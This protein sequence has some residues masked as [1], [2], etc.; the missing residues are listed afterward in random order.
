VEAERLTY[1]GERI[2]TT[3]RSA[4]KSATLLKVFEQKQGDD[5]GMYALQSGL[6]RKTRLRRL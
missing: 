3:R 1:L 5:H 2:E 4:K 6:S